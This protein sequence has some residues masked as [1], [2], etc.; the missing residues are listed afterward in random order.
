MDGLIS[1]I[2]PVHN[3]EAF[4]DECIRSMV[5][6]TY[7][8]IEIVLVDDGSTD[9]SPA[10]CDAWAEKDSRIV[11]I[12]QPGSGVSVARN[13]GIEVSKGDYLYFVD[14]DD[15]IRADL[16]RRAMEAIQDNQADVVAFG[17][18]RVT[19]AGE[20]YETIPGQD[21]VMDKEA[22]LMALSQH[23]LIN[24]CWSKVY[25]REIWQELRFPEGRLFEDVATA[26]KV[27]LQADRVCCIPDALYCYRKR[28]G[29]IVA[30]VSAR[31]LRDL[32]LMLKQM[33]DDLLPIYP[34]MAENMFNEVV[35]S[36]KAY[37]DHAIDYKGEQHEILDQVTAFLQ[38]NKTQI[39]ETCGT[40]LK[41]YYH[42]PG[43]YRI[44]RRVR[45]AT[46]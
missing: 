34:V 33:Y 3:V 43:L 16:C 14:S 4:L 23:K 15:Y 21:A 42:C 22:A 30:A 8:N 11:V 31:S 7:R 46:K 32:F 12:H 39:L 25:K 41:L 40:E 19:E 26:Y 29:S 17:T 5:E 20:V 44:Y 37:A 45:R 10:I 24:S 28:E 36:A 18:T 13:K 6:Q 9:N 27:L 2:V 1:I 38:E 35:R